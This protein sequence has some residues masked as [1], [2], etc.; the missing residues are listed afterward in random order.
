MTRNVFSGLFVCLGMVSFFIALLSISAQATPEV[1]PE[2]TPD[3]ITSI[4]DLIVAAFTTT[5]T[6]PLT[7]QP[8]DLTLSIVI[9]ANIQL[10]GWPEFPES[11]GAFV[12]GQV[13]EPKTEVTTAGDTIYRQSLMVYL[14]APGEYETP[15]TLVGYRFSDSTDIYYVPARA[16]TFNVPTVLESLDLN[17]LSR[18]P[19]RPPIDFFYIPT[20]VIAVFITILVGIVWVYL[21]LVEKY[22]ARAAQITTIPKTPA[23]IVLARLTEIRKQSLSP[24][25]A[26][27]GVADSLRAYIQGCYIDIPAQELTTA[28]VVDI[29]RRASAVQ[30]DPARLDEFRRLLEQADLVKFAN[31]QPDKRLAGRMLKWA[32]RW[33]KAV[34]QS[35]LEETEKVVESEVYVE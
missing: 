12:V 23:E 34:D 16:I 30:F 27:M 22:R 25:L 5:N 15:E 6:A 4:D 8:T 10:V 7:G 20:Y 26:C 19:N 17:T 29:L 14:W 35:G 11:W 21:R 2:I 1:T 24:A 9:P 31:I 32:Y 33:V 18:Q 3:V 13:G 28:E